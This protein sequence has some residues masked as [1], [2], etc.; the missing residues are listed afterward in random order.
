MYFFSLAYRI[1]PASFVA[2]FEYSGMIW[3]VVFGLLFWGDVP[4]LSTILGGTLVATA[5]IVMLRL[6]ARR[7]KSRRAGQ[8]AG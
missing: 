7:E 3:A 6:D 5:G 2:P 4:S 1:G 8:P